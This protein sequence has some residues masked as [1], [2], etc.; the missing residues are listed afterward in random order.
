MGR[1]IDL[2]M[3]INV[4]AIHKAALLGEADGSNEFTNG[5]ALAYRHIC[6]LISVLPPAQLEQRVG[7]WIKISPAGIYECSKCGQNVMT[8][9]IDCYK[10]CHGCG[11]KMEGNDGR[12]D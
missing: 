2:D 4:I 6:E 8:S 9:D 5:Y 12:P 1:T 3:A 7:K 11:I 10:W